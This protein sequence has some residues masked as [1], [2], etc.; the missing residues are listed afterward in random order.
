MKIIFNDGSRFIVHDMSDLCTVI[1][2]SNKSSIW[3][4]EVNPYEFENKVLTAGVE[5]DKECL[6]KKDD[7][8]GSY[9]VYKDVCIQTHE[10]YCL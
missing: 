4:V 9:V 5:F 2:H 6:S 10:S 3:R 8:S 7:L 1:K